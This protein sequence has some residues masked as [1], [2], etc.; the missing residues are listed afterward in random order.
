MD[1]T[2]DNPGFWLH[3]HCQPHHRGLPFSKLYI[4]LVFPYV[5][6]HLHTH[7]HTDTH[8]DTYTQT[9]A[10]THTHRDTYIHTD[11]HTYTHTQTHTCMHTDTHT[12]IHRHTH[13]NRTPSA[14]STQ[15]PDRRCTNGFRPQDKTGWLFASLCCMSFP[16]ATIY[17]P[18]QLTLSRVVVLC[19]SDKYACYIPHLYA[20]LE[21]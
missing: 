4:V 14:P 12:H 2:P 13:R 3:F 6:G 10:H 21:P 1:L 18:P 16:T 17:P 8:T 20:T 9:H 5:I 11:T 15:V 19:F 7:I